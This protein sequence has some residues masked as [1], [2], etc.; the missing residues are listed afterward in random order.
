MVLLLSH[1]FQHVTILPPSCV[2]H[3]Q[4]LAAYQLLKDKLHKTQAKEDNM[5]VTANL[6]D[7]VTHICLRG[8]AQ[9]SSIML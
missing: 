2:L 3:P 7:I 5:L 8:S 9:L 4:E 6:K 1:L